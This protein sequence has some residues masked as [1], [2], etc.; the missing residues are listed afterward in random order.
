MPIL[1]KL[2]DKRTQKLN[3]AFL[4]ELGWPAAHISGALGEVHGEDALSASC[5]RRIHKAVEDGDETFLNDQRPG[6]IHERP[7]SGDPENMKKVKERI[8]NN[9]HISIRTLVALTGLSQKVIQSILKRLN[10]IKRFGEFVPRAPIRMLRRQRCCACVKNLSLL[11]R[12]G[13][14]LERVI[15]EDECWLVHLR[16]AQRPRA[17]SMVY[18]R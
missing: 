14:L 8:V 16:R 1:E 2:A 18:R 13:S 12:D 15:A 6:A 11:E 10:M 3:V 4:T 5:V 17:L 7:I 9:P